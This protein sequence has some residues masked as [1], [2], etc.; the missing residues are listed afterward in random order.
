MKRVLIYIGYF[1]LTLA[2]G[3]AVSLFLTLLRSREGDASASTI[4]QDVRSTTPPAVPVRE[5]VVTD[6]TK[7]LELSVDNTDVELRM[8]DFKSLSAD[9]MLVTVNDTVYLLN[10]TKEVIW[11]TYLDLAAPPIVDSNGNIFGIL[12]DLGHC[13]VNADTGE[14]SYFGR[15]IGG[16][17]SY[18]T[19]IKPYKG[20]QY[21]VVENLQFYRDGNLCYPRCP[22]R[23]DVLHAWA[24]Q[25]L[26]W[27]IDFPPNAELEVWG[28]KI[29][30]VTRQQH[31]IIV[32][33]IE[34]PR[35]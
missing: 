28:N 23:S 27:S 9:R 7:G 4:V 10:A 15:D 1:A 20:N 2:T 3:V 19:Q 11:Q 12:G 26:L 33:Q 35:K 5:A 16:S 32:E 34:P 24:G 8:V 25:K 14:V 6:I 31:S 22:M 21:L 30:A 17:H 13:S 29:L 18:Y